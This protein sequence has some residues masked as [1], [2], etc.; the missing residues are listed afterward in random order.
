MHCLQKMASIIV[1]LYPGLFTT[2]LCRKRESLSLHP[3]KPGWS[4][5]FFS[6]QDNMVDVILQEF[7]T[8]ALMSLVAS[9]C[10]HAA[11]PICWGHAQASLVE[12]GR[13]LRDHLGPISCCRGICVSPG[14]I[15]Q[16]EARSAVTW[17]I[18]RLTSNNKGLF[19]KFT[20]R[21]LFYSI[22]EANCPILIILGRAG[23]PS[24]CLE[25]TP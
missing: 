4:S 25:G 19:F 1:S 3:L 5:D 18:C 10:S 13:H 20:K 15:S 6:D 12:D 11:L 14:G 8:C 7:W 23:C 9:P 16:T 2:Y 17:L 21:W 22:V 24:K